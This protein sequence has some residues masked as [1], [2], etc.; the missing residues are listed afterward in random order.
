MAQYR[1]AEDIPTAGPP[2]ASWS[3]AAEQGIGNVGKVPSRPPAGALPKAEVSPRGR[4]LLVDALRGIAALWVVLF[5]AHEGLHLTELVAKLPRWS[6]LVFEAGWM[7]VPIFFVLSGFVITYSVAKYKVDRGF[8]WRFALRRSIRLDPP[9][10][11]SMGVAVG[12]GILSTA[13]V[14][15]K[16]FPVPTARQLLAHVLYVQDLFRIPQ[17]NDI[18]WTL[19]LEIQFYLLFCLLMWISHSLR[20]DERDKRWLYGLFVPALT[21][22]A[23]F[24]VLGLPARWPGTFLTHWHGF[25]L[26]MLACWVVSGTVSTS[27]FYAFIAVMCGGA[28]RAGM[29]G[30]HQGALFTGACT[31]TAALLSW[32]GRRGKIGTWLRWPPL[33]FLGMISYSLYLIHNPITG[34]A[35][36]VAFRLTSRS[37][38]SE[39]FWLAAIVALNIAAA[40]VVW[41]SVERPS[42]A[43]SHRIKFRR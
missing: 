38:L 2:A 35:F 23:A 39:A 40:Y 8:V 24:P 32:T 42:M 16:S 14:K 31:A 1:H 11:V 5:H 43:L 41:W 37:A 36:N 22:A 12:F 18:Y 7:G 27:L 4:F 3:P 17:I 10:W 25:L 6:T 21:V 30:D 13:F 34:A 9:Y 19:C 33:Q 28:I 26:G 29:H 15:G 20:R